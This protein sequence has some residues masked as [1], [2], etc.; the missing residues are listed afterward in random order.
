MTSKYFCDRNIMDLCMLY[1]MEQIQNFVKDFMKTGQERSMCLFIRPSIQK[2]Y[3]IDPDWVK[4][5]IKLRWKRR[6]QQMINVQSFITCKV[7]TW[8]N[9]NGFRSGLK[10]R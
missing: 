10:C 7:D 4:F 6:S 5:Y 2:D 9:Q 3:V 1:D 8:G